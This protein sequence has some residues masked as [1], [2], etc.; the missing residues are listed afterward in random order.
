MEHAQ[1]PL[2][3]LASPDS[4]CVPIRLL[5]AD[6]PTWWLTVL[7]LRPALDLSNPLP[8]SRSLG[9]WS[10]EPVKHIF[11]PC[12]AFIPNAKGY[13]VLSKS[14]QAFLKGMFRVSDPFAL[15]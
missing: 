8:P 9:R 6:F 10:A 1:G 5:F 15:L 11:L 12:S 14:M 13:P 4:E 3:L 7:L 2:Q